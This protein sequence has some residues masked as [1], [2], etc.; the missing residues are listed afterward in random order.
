MDFV[1]I[2]RR[3]S[4]RDRMRMLKTLLSKS[5]TK[6]LTIRDVINEWQL[7]PPYIVKLMRWCADA[8]DY[9]MFDEN[10]GVLFMVSAKS[11]IYRSIQAQTQLIQTE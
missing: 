11:P 5:E 7:T 2:K 4:Y 9:I 8:N 3:V 10:F 6:E 1:K